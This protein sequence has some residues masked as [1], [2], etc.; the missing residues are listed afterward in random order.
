[1][2]RLTDDQIQQRLPALEGWSVRGN[3]LQKTFAFA[4]FADA[5]A[6][7]NRVAAEAEAVD[8]HPDI[9]VEYR[10]VTLTLSTHSAGG[11]TANDT[12]LA[13]RLTAVSLL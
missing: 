12:D 9:L 8:H 1:M 13:A 10:N 4:A 5:I 3:A 11:I 6:F 7:V 2:E